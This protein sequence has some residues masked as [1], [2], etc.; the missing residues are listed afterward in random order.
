M[1]LCKLD[2]CVGFKT[3]VRRQLTR[4]SVAWI[5]ASGPG[6]YVACFAIHQ[7]VNGR[8]LKIYTRVMVK[9]VHNSVSY[10]SKH[11]FVGYQ[12]H[13]QI[14]IVRYQSFTCIFI[15]SDTECR[16]FKRVPRHFTSPSKNGLM[17]NVWGTALLNPAMA[18]HS[19][20][21]GCFGCLGCLD[22]YIG[23]VNI[24]TLAV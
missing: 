22:Y 14:D 10:N 7:C 19:P 2:K 16:N 13:W 5:K 3:L 15:W 9:I 12:I 8:Y 4:L 20:S 1:L 17:P 6:S 24:T 11:I 18:A 21:L 23:C